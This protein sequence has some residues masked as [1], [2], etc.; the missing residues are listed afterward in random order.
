MQIDQNT[1]FRLA[2]P[3]PDKNKKFGTG[4]AVA[5]KDKRL[6]ILTCAH[7][8]KDLDD[9][10]KV[11]GQEIDQ[12]D[13]VKIGAIDAIDLA[14]LS[15]PWD[16][17]PPPLQN[18]ITK[19]EEGDKIQLRGFSLVNKNYGLRRIEGHLGQNAPRQSSDGGYIPTWDL[20]ITDDDF[21]QLKGGYS[22]SP[23]CDENGRLIGVVSERVANGKYGYAVDISNLKTIYPEIESLS[24]SFSA[25]C[26]ALAPADRIALAKKQL[27]SLLP[28]FDI[29]DKL[30]DRLT[31][32]VRNEFKRM[33]EKGLC[34]EDEALLEKIGNAADRPDEWEVLVRFLE[35]L[36]QKRQ[37][38][39]EG[40]DYLRLAKQLARGEV[41]LCLGQEISH[42]LGA[43]IPSTAE[44]KKC[45]CQGGCQAP[46]SELCE[47]KLISP[48]SSR[49][50]LVHEFR[51]LMDRKTSTVVLHEVLADFEQ[52]FMVI[53]AGYDNML[54][55]ILRAKRRDFVEIYPNMEEGKCLLIY[56]DKEEVSCTPDKISALD[57]IK[58]GYSVIYRLRGGIVGNQEH[59]LLAER[60]Y[61]A[62]N[63]LIEQQF[64][65]Y[66]SKRL[67][68]SLCSLWFIG[69][70]PQSWEER[71]L[72]GFLKE[73]Q[74]NDAAS[75][76]VQE[77]I[78]SFDHDFWR[79]KGVKVH[80]LALADFVQKLEAAL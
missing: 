25:L 4:F 36:D 24:P 35:S 40:P 29:D 17:S 72:I 43:Q 52:P 49:T 59:L 30:Y 66:I 76:V 8:V 45:L 39:A 13:I 57:P 5:C 9:R 58:D 14:L 56:S 27:R 80:D 16:D 38:I 53:S 77:N 47:Q 62:F 60:D 70:H 15:I 75:L 1:V 63:R 7:V 44:I 54:Q 73:L 61:F 42:L 19:R 67:K 55:E 50:D 78:P 41:I 79:Y 21:C 32:A 34:P 23:L 11:I 33:E 69:H 2:S 10:V 64:P 51:E 74:H 18:R 46:L 12:A 28:D 68:S 31:K 22:G 20:H 48:R 37:D 71:L 6:F 65:N 3:E 26:T